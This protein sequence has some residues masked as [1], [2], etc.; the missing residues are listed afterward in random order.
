MNNIVVL[1]D[2]N[3][4]DVEFEVIANF[5]VD[6][7]EYSVLYPLGKEDEEALLFKIIS[8]DGE[9]AVLEYIEDEKEFETVSKVYYELMN[10]KN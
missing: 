5:K 6:E 2:E 8:E 10:E 7:D 1:K 3:G 4:V 9:E